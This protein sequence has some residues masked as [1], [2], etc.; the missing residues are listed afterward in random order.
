[1]RVESAQPRDYP[2]LLSLWEASVRA[3]HD[4]LAEEHLQ[5]LKPRLVEEYFPAVALYCAADEQKGIVGFSGV[6]DGRLEMLFVD[7]TH[8]G[9]GI[10]SLLVRHAIE[11]QGV[12]RVDVNEQNPQALGFYRHRGFV[13]TDRSAQ[14]AQGWDYPLLHL[15]L[16]VERRF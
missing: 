12:W 2:R 6:L 10:G 11:Q 13:V 3:T 7:P 5:T 15:E 1:M 9:Q 14:D 4:F 8:R 16:P